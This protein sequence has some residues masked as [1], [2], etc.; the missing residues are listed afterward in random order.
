MGERNEEEINA[1]RQHVTVNKGDIW[2]FIVL[3]LQ[4]YC[5]LENVQNKKLEEKGSIRDAIPENLSIFKD[6]PPEIA[7]SEIMVSQPTPSPTHWIYIL[8]LTAIL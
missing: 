1:K 4:L 2:T 6:N 3:F 7:D 5:R 8:H